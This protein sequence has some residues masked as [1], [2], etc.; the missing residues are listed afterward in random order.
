MIGLIIN[1]MPAN[2]CKKIS[3]FPLLLLKTIY[4]KFYKLFLERLFYFIMPIKCCS[5]VKTRILLLLLLL[6][7]LPYSVQV[8]K[9]CIK[10]GN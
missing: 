4:K 3:F 9:L 10:G 2:V 7:D 8:Q 1:N 6:K 5:Y